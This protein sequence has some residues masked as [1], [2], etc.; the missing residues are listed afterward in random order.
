MVVVVISV[1]VMVVVICVVCALV[2]EVVVTSVFLQAVNAES[3]TIPLI[4][5][6]KNFLIVFL[7]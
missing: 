2:V 6:G 4:A 5:K 7:S 1:V 3:K